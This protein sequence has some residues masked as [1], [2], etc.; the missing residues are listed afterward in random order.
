MNTLH[1]RKILLSWYG[2][3]KRDL[4]WRDTSS[5]YNIWISEIILQQTRI[6]QGIH[7]YNRF[8]EKYPDVI[9]LALSAEQEVLKM[10][11]GLGYYS[12]ARNLLFASKQI[13]NDYNGI[14]PTNSNEIKKLKGVG[15][16]TA[17]AIASI[18]FNEP[19]AAIDGNVYRVLS[20][21]F[22]IDAPINSGK[23]KK[24]F[25]ELANQLIDPK[26]PGDF[27]QAIMEFGALQCTPVN[28]ECSICPFQSVCLAF[29]NETVK[30]F[31]VKIK[32]PKVRDRYFNY[33]VIEQGQSFFFNKR[34][35]Q[36]IWKNLY[37]F[38]L[39]ETNHS[40]EPEKLILSDDWESL[41]NNEKVSITHIS[42]EIIHILSHQRIHARFYHI[43]PNS[44]KNLP[45]QYVMINKKD[46]FGLPVP[47]IME[48]YLFE[49]NFIK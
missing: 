4:P 46:I 31:P 23:G 27:N 29:I 16:Y 37:D 30:Y 26:Q 40:I 22:T 6:N 47:K 24:Q 25:K 18:V 44:M 20:R 3:H 32:S 11:Q 34:V 43:L 36:D 39:L 45:S 17:A 1:F 21:I 2:S 19:V 15:E 49:M 28:P 5:P 14:F 12:R 8:V 7:Y 38:P 9:T 42:E 10:W 35:D 48:T 13:L 41:F 33:L